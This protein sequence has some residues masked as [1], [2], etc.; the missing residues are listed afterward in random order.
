MTQETINELAKIDAPFGREVILQDV[1]HES[2]MRMMRIRIKEGSRFTI[3][4][5]DWETA[6]TWNT[7]FS[8]WIKSTQNG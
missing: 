1:T 7:I 3:M 8:D 6:R 5:I 4:D 2:G